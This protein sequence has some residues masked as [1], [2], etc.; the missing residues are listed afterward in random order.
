[1]RFFRNGEEKWKEIYDSEEDMK[2]LYNGWEEWTESKG[3]KINDGDGTRKTFHYVM[4]T[5]YEEETPELEETNDESEDENG[6][7]IGGGYSSDRG[8]SQHSG[9]WQRG[10]L[11]DKKMPGGEKGENLDSSDDEDEALRFH[12]EPWKKEKGGI[13]SGQMV[14]LTKKRKKLQRSLKRLG[15][16]SSPKGVLCVTCWIVILTVSTVINGV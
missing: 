11:R 16:R 14:Y 10:K 4:G 6:F 1:M 3:K 5:W 7:G 8:R 13:D 9:A 12:K 2:I 15:P